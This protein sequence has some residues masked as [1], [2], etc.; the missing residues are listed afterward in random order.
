MENSFLQRWRSS[1]SRRHSNE[2]ARSTETR[3][4]VL[5][6]HLLWDLFEFQDMDWRSART[7]LDH[8]VSI[9]SY[10]VNHS[11]QHRHSLGSVADTPEGGLEPSGAEVEE[12]VRRL[13]A[14]R[15]QNN[16]Q[17]SGQSH[18][19]P[20][21]RSHRSSR[22]PSFVNALGRVFTSNSGANARRRAS[23]EVRRGRLSSD[24]EAR[25]AEPQEHR[26]VQG[27]QEQP[28]HSQEAD[29]PIDVAALARMLDDMIVRRSMYPDEGSPDGP[30]EENDRRQ[31]SASID[32]ATVFL[33]LR[34]LRAHPSGRERAAHRLGED[35]QPHESVVQL[36]EVLSPIPRGATRWAIASLPTRTWTGK[37][38]DVSVGASP[39]EVRGGPK[40]LSEEKDPYKERCNIC[41]CDYDE[42]DVV[43]TLPC[44]HWFHADCVD[45]WLRSNGTCPICKNR[46]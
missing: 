4:L 42:G 26:P 23:Q 33:R 19:A 37:K 9:R 2:Q 7:S 22:W 35:S 20:G 40:R 39:G 10:P 18:Q 11:G 24:W 44:L 14:I 45:R 16:V 29:E 32:A 17:R 31:R 3:V 30:P 36:Q 38:A 12:L 34:E 46:V 5:T 27:A 25:P 8:G 43:R 1:R 13:N 21:S 41:L 28:G 15:D 6:N